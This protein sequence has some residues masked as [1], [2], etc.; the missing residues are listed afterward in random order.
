MK[1]KLIN[2]AAVLILTMALVVTIAITVLMV[3]G[4]FKLVSLIA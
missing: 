3:T 1:D 4:I 2:G